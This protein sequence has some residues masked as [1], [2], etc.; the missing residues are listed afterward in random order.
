MMMKLHQLQLQQI[1]SLLR[2]HLAVSTGDAISVMNGSSCIEACLYNSTEP[3]LVSNPCFLCGK[4]KERKRMRAPCRFYRFIISSRPISRQMYRFRDET[5][6][7][8][9]VLDDKQV[10]S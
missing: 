7:Y 9:L 8:S 3:I 10:F 1:N 6:H 5:I 4:K 2:N